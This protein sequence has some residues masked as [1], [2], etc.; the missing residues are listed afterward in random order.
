MIK[1]RLAGILCHPTS[2]PSPFG[3]GDFGQEAYDFIDFLVNAGQS[4]W[5]ILPL[6]PVG[7][8]NSPYQSHGAFA[9]NIYLISPELLQ[10]KGYLTKLQLANPPDLN[11]DYVEFDRVYKYKN[12]LFQMAYENFKKDPGAIR[13]FAKF[14]AENTWLHDFALFE[15]L[16]EFLGHLPLHDW[17]KPLFDKEVPAL[18]KYIE[19][20]QD[21]INYRKYL[22]FEFYSQWDKLKA[23]ANKN[24]VKII[25]DLP[26]FVSG[27]SADYWANKELFLKDKD[28]L[29]EAVAGVPPD[30][31]SE[32]G[33][34]WGNPLYDFKAQKQNGYEWWVKR[35]KHNLSMFDIVRIDHFRG[36]ESFWQIPA[37]SKTAIK[38]KWVKG[39][40]EEFFA[41]IEKELGSLAVIAEDLGII[42]PEVN[43]LR[44]NLGYPGMKILHFAFMDGAKSSYLPHNFDDSNTV[45]YTGT[46]DNNTTIGWYHELDENIK[47]FVRRYLRIS[48][49]DIAWDLIR[50]C[51]SSSA[52][53]AIIPIQDLMS[54]GGEARMNTPG[55]ADGNW[56]F[57]FKKEMLSDDIAQGLKY[58]C[59]LYNR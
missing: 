33:Q 1:K 37:N 22:Q 11:C 46:H 13:P 58:L 39:P 25:G 53:T 24:E 49:D 30:Y 55:T 27:S 14:C 35:F 23:Y 31:F 59:E 47:D 54:L 28:G 29:P 2:L 5:Q 44:E 36:F 7:Y 12:A 18:K 19:R 15:S 48:G 40:G 16:S 4:Y 57:R 52:N 26:I 56:G 50:L 51:F 32:S 3:I 41:T 8:G 45:V 34:L 17:P 6:T 10:K 21:E 42:T 20:L 9:G 43:K 38:G